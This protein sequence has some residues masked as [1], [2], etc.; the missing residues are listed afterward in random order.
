MIVRGSGSTEFYDVYN[1]H[2]NAG[3]YVVYTP[4]CRWSQP[5]IVQVQ[6]IYSNLCVV[7]N[8]IGYSGYYLHN[9]CVLLKGYVE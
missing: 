8:G 6:L 9:R 4:T 2:I 7:V 1:N 3:D 5:R